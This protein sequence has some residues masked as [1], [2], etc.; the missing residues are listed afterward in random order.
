MRAVVHLPGEG[1]QIGLGSSSSVTIKA[2]GK[3]TEGSFHLSE[4]VII[5]GYAGPPPRVHDRQHDMFYVLEGTLTLQI[6]DETVDLGP[7][8]FACIPP[9]IVHTFSN[10]GEQPLRFLN[11]DTPAGKEDRMRDMAAAAHTAGSLTSEEIARIS[12]RHDWRVA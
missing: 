10:R 12:S 3:D 1:E 4:A 8:S 9:G 6:G 11:F 2:T 7:G 5:P